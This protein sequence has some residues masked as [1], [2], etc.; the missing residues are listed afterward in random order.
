VNGPARALS[1]GE[2]IGELGRRGYL[3]V[4][5]EAGRDL[6]G[7]AIEP[8]GRIV[9]WRGEESYLTPRLAQVLGVLAA[10]WPA[11]TST[12]ILRSAVWGG[13]TAE[14]TVSEAVWQLRRQ[15]PQLIQTL[16]GGRG[17]RLALGGR[18]A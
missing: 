1:D 11:S 16:P 17:Y 3:A 2:L 13:P 9:R 7:L 10:R 15:L 14:G 4:R 12:A 6:P 8:G 5:T 18:S